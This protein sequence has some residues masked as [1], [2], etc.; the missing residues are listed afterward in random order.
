[1]FP[2]CVLIVLLIRLEYGLSMVS[3]F[4]LLQQSEGT[5]S[6]TTENPNGSFPSTTPLSPPSHSVNSFGE[7]FFTLLIMVLF[8]LLMVWCSFRRWVETKQQQN[9]IIVHVLEQQEASGQRNAAPVRIFDEKFTNDFSSELPTKSTARL[10][11]KT[12]EPISQQA[13]G[14]FSSGIQDVVVKLEGATS[15]VTKGKSK[16]EPTTVPSLPDLTVEPSG[17]TCMRP[18]KGSKKTTSEIS[19]SFI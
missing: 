5:T 16:S 8:V 11:A 14:F 6:G 15:T 19:K 7:F 18:K 17:R 3:R 2:F 1:M 4:A 9:E 13:T 12:L 10:S